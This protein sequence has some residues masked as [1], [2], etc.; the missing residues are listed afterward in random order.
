MKFLFFKKVE[1]YIVIGLYVF[2]VRVNAVEFFFF[3]IWLGE[4]C[5]V[6]WS[7]YYFLYFS[8]YEGWDG[9]VIIYYCLYF[10]FLIVEKYFFFIDN[11]IKMREK[12][13]IDLWS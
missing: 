9:V 11:D 4:F 13:K 8:W 7:F 2:E 1:D 5:W 3:F 10:C 12:L 6:Y